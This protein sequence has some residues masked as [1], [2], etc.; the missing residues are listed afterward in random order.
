M[1]NK[2]RNGKGIS[3]HI[4]K[5]VSGHQVALVGGR[6]RDVEDALACIA[7]VCCRLHVDVGI[8]EADCACV[9]QKESE[10]VDRVRCVQ[11][12]FWRLR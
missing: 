11:G 8:A 1:H 5:G 3:S 12:V 2:E 10:C 6:A 4:A 7:V 9:S